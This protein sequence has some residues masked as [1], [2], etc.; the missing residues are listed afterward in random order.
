MSAGLHLKRHEEQLVC[1]RR[2]L[3]LVLRLASERRLAW[4]LELLLL[5]LLVSA[6]RQRVRRR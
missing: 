4:A 2:V 1:A 5:A 3:V 6:R